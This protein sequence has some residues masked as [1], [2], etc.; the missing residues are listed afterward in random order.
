MNRTPRTSSLARRLALTVALSG[1]GLAGL[2][3]SPAGAVPPGPGD[4]TTCADEVNGCDQPDDTIDDFTNGEPDVDEPGDGTDDGGTD[5]G[6]TDGGA[7]V[8]GADELPPAPVGDVV[9][10]NPTFTG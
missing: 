6:G 8:D 7:S 5:D 1:V 3:A 2:I 10:A 4:L 9:V